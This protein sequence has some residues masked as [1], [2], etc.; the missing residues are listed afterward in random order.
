MDRDTNGFVLYLQP[1]KNIICLLGLWLCHIRKEE[2]PFKVL[3]MPVSF[4][5]VLHEVSSLNRGCEQ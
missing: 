5:K 2:I 3:E 1:E 4:A